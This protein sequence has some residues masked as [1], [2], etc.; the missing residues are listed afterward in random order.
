MIGRA[1]LDT[2]VHILITSSVRYS[3]YLQNIED[4]G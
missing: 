4:I 3:I 1:L 2:R